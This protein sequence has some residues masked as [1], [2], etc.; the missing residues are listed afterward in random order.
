VITLSG[1]KR[2]AATARETLS[3]SR[4][5]AATMV[6]SAFF[7]YTLLAAMLSIIQ[8]NTGAILG[9]VG[10]VCISSTEFSGKYHDYLCFD[11]VGF[12]GTNTSVHHGRVTIAFP[13]AH[14]LIWLL[15]VQWWACIALMVTMTY[16]MLSCFGFGRRKPLANTHE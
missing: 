5:A 9:H 12:V 1:D 3:F 2:V 16:W 10:S 7:V 13:G 11:D 4:R 14:T 8:R 6:W 15:L